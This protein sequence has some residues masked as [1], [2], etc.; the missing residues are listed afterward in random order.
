[1][2]EGVFTMKNMKN[3]KEWALDGVDGANFGK[4]LPVF[5]LLGGGDFAYF[6]APNE[7]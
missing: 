5:T 4:V 3:M 2:E 7:G 1:M 6:W